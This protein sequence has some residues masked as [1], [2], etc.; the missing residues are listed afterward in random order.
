MLATGK[1]T[2]ARMVKVLVEEEMGGTTYS[3]QYL[4]DSKDTLERYYQED[5]ERLRLEAMKLFADKFVA[6][7]TELEIISEH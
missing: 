6:F 2:N 1:F 4:T 7:R 3:V 5:A